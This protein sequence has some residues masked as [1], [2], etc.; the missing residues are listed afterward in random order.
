MVLFFEVGMLV[1]V[2]KFFVILVVDVGEIVV[3]VEWG[4]VVFILL[5]MLC[6]LV[7]MVVVVDGVLWIGVL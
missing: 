4:G 1:W 5:F 2:D 6:W 7:E 3:V